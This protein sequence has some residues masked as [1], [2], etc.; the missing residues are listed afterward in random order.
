MSGSKARNLNPSNS[1]GTCVRTYLK[2]CLP[3][4]QTLKISFASS[5]SFTNDGNSDS[6]RSPHCFIESDCGSHDTQ[7][8][9]SQFNGLL[10]IVT[11]NL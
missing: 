10:F 8:K 1:M 6:Y 7:S 3:G 2:R 9:F 4:A 11:L 5:R